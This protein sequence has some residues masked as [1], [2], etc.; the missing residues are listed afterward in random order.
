VAAVLNT[1]Y[2]LNYQYVGDLVADVAAAIA[3]EDVAQVQ[4]L[5]NV[6]AGLNEAGCPLGNSSP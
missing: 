1:G 4:A 3:S 6:L 2:G 5:K